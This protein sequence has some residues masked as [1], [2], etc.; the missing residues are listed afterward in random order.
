MPWAGRLPA[1]SITVAASTPRSPWD[2][3]SVILS[4]LSALRCKTFGLF[5]LVAST[6]RTKSC[7]ARKIF[8]SLPTNLSKIEK[9]IVRT[10][11]CGLGDSY[12]V[13]ATMRDLLG[14]P[15]ACTAVGTHGSNTF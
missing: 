14:A 7:L 1:H 4:L 13:W 12:W 8:G 9:G 3:P 11:L 6:F 2:A 10:L 15:T 5:W